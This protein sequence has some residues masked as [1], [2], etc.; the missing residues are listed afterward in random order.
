MQE[1][2]LAAHGGVV[3]SVQYRSRRKGY[4]VEFQIGSSAWAWARD[5]VL[6]CFIEPGSEDE[7]RLLR[8]NHSFQIAI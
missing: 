8:H 5:R 3:Q 6:L 2:K 1:N 7:H 4:Q